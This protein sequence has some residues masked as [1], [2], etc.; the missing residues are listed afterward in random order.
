MK[1][2]IVAFVAAGTVVA[3]RPV[4]KRRMVQKMR[5]HCKQMMGQFE[6]GSETTS[7]EAM[8][9]EAMRHKMR[10]HCGQMASHDEGRS[11]PVATA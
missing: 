10:K 9:P 3:L 4:V 2:L 8:G 5:E 6:G 7:H 1:K 11:E